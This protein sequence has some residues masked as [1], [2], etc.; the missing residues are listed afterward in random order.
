MFKIGISGKANSGK[1]TLSKMLVKELC[2]Q[3]NKNIVNIQYLAFADPIKEMICTMYPSLPKKY[4]YGPSKFRKE[5]IPNSFDKNGNP[6]SV[7]QLLTDLGTQ[8]R[9][10][11]ENIWI[12][13]FDKRFDKKHQLTIVSDVRYRNEFD[14]LRNKNFFIIRLCRPNN[15]LNINHAS[16][17]DQLLINDNEFDYILINNKDIKHLQNEVV[18]NIMPKLLNN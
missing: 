18:N 15:D 3:N 8:G 13:N 17:T 1:D 5:I 16:E 6:L 14:Y 7:R 2:S 10:Y 4:L 11:D 9:N 12:D